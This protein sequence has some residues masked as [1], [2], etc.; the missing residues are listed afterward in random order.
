MSLFESSITGNVLNDGSTTEISGITAG[1]LATVLTAYTPLTDTAANTAA[2]GANAAGLAAL[3]AQVAALPP[4]PNLA[5]Y[6]L[7]ADLAS[8]EGSIAAN[9]SS[10][11]ALNTS[12]VTSLAGKANQSALDALQLEVD[13]KSTPASV[14]AKLAGYSNTAA[15]NSAIAS[16]NNATLATVG[17]AYA[18]RTVTAKQSGPDV[19]SKI[20]TALLDRPSS[21]DLTTAVNLKTTPADVDQKVATALLTCVTQ[22]ALDA[23][24]ALRDGRH[25]S[26]E[27]SIASLQAAGFQTAAQVASAIATALLPYTDTTG[28]NS[29]LAVRDGRLDSAETSV[30]ALQAAGYQTSAQVASALAAALL[31][32]V[33]QTGLDAALALRDLRL[34]A[35]E[36][37]ITLL[38]DRRRR[39]EPGQRAGLARRDYL[40]PAGGHQ[41][42]P[43]PALCC[44][45][46]RESREREFHPEPRLRL[47]QHCTNRCGHRYGSGALR[48]GRAARRCHRCRP[49]RVQ[50]RRLGFLAQ[51]FEGTGITGTTYMGGKEELLT[52]D[53]SRLTAVLWGVC[54]QLQ[55]RIE[56]LEKPKKAQRRG[57]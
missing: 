9:Q 8:A 42:D 26:A 45:F 44:A 21:T 22:V 55:R 2:V 48:D 54:K 4:P 12:L 14:D 51:D 41:H 6:A 13:A 15:M 1:Q 53:Y 23:A 28:L 5:P 38:P 52:L 25:D 40:G 3:Q 31:P 27:A 39:A 47:I 29:L 32:Y 37:S 19:D 46:E 11:T 30:A 17:S 10:I 35:A 49:G 34:D 7:A 24:L 50:H 57:E 16:A 43:E 20:A 56:A 33:Q 18:L 36:T